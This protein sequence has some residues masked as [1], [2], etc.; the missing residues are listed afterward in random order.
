M[1]CTAVLTATILLTKEKTL[2]FTLKQNIYKFLVANICLCTC[3]GTQVNTSSFS[4][5]QMYS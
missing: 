2:K 5:G 4:T 1:L 3:L